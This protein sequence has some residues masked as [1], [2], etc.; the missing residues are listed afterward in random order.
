[1]YYFCYL[2]LLFVVDV[3]ERKSME[4]LK[5]QSSNVGSINTKSLDDEHATSNDFISKLEEIMRGEANKALRQPSKFALMVLK[6]GKLYCRSNQNELYESR[7][8]DF[9]EMLQLGLRTEQG[10]KTF[11]SLNYDLPIILKHDDSSGCNAATRTD[12]YGFPRLSWALPVNNT[13]NWCHAIG[14]PSYISWRTFKR[15]VRQWDAFFSRNDNLY[16]WATKIR[17]A[18]WR[19][20]TTSNKSLYGQLD[21]LETP[22]GRL[23]NSSIGNSF[24]D[25][26]FNKLV[27]K[28][29]GTS[30]QRQKLL[31]DSIP[32]EQMMKYK[33]IIDIDGNNWSSRFNFLLCFNSVIIKISPDFVE[34]T[35]HELV[36]GVHYV[37]A[38]LNNITQVAE[39]V[40]VE[41][42][43][44]DLQQIISNAN[45]WC[46]K[47]MT[48]D[49]L[50]RSAMAALEEY[51]DLLNEFDRNW[52][53]KW[54]IRG[55]F[56]VANDIVECTL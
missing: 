47:S 13:A 49:A 24:I 20:S 31:K 39:S 19:G 29:K 5:Q 55:A 56:E 25:S 54:L 3:V 28:H 37:P 30:M 53:E 35:F 51:H 52:Q 36:P 40:L 33:A 14:A 44:K 41:N 42:N 43:D 45:S 16:P 27:G 17:K 32:M 2:L 1:M 21:L 50:G 10:R 34:S 48:Q 8:R 22:R 38:S 6:H 18:V 15:N 12:S 4:K 7:S 9:A 46:A 23:V 26:G 11:G